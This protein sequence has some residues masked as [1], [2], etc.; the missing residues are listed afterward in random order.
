MSDFND[1]PISVIMESMMKQMA[2]GAE[3]HQ[4]FTCAGC[5]SRLTIET[6]NR[7]FTKGEC[8]NCDTVTDIEAQGCNFMFILPLGRG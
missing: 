1:Y 7:L 8:D 2:R 3:C 5:G 6:P 4:K